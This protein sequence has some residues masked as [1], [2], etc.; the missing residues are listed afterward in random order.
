[1][2]DEVRFKKL[3]FVRHSPAD[4][5]ARADAFLAELRSRRSVRAFS[6]EEIPAGVVEACI[7]AAAQAPSGAHK[8]PWTFVLVKDKGLRS[9]IRAAAE[10][11]EEAFYSGRA[12][13]KWLKDVEP[14]G[15][16][17]HK[18]FLEDAHTLIVVF[19]QR[20]GDEIQDRHYYV[21]ESVGIAVG[22]LLCALHHA[23]LVAL[24]HTPAPMAFLRELLGRPTNERAFCII[25]VGL[26]AED[27]EVP[28][29]E[30]KQ[31][32]EVLVER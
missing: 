1:M 17:K 4:M 16:D 7:E 2:N 31:L 14:F 18:P 28:E 24:T 9:A 22:M 19:A 27:C 5:K 6:K 3:E 26:P 11:E 15:T 8:Q 20:H 13:A 30:R 29:L 12:S 21:S 10:K 23:G 25:P 32:S